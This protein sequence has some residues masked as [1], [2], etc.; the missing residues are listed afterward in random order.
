MTVV[1]F[2]CSHDLSSILGGKQIV[3]PFLIPLWKKFDSKFFFL[4]NFWARKRLF[5]GRLLSRKSRKLDQRK[6]SC[7]VRI[8]SCPSDFVESFCAR[9]PLIHC[10]AN[11][12][13][14]Y[15]TIHERRGRNA[16]KKNDVGLFFKSCPET[17][18][19][20]TVVSTPK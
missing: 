5:W 16:R 8:L 9:P 20:I 12:R 18:T 10:T 6:Y 17:V 19:L 14:P 2:T 15:C 3:Q 13:P 7:I 11:L 4:R 1:E